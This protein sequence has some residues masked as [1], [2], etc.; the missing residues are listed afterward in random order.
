MFSDNF[1]SLIDYA[2]KVLE[3]ESF[4]GFEISC[5]DRLHSLT[6][7][8]NSTIHQ[9]VSDHTYRFRF[10]ASEGKKLGSISLSSL[11]ITSIDNTIKQLTT[12]VRRMSK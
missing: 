5:V 4:D 12:S 9:N 1:N 7:Y 11:T 6:R 3:S 8:A 10:R 2:V